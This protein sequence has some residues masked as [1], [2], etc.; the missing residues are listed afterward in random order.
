MASDLTIRPA[1][2]SDRPAMECVCAHTFD[3]GDYIPEVWDD[4]LADKQGTV[5]VGEVG[6]R[7]VAL[8]RITFQATGQVYIGG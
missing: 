7:M 6:E 3:W 8:S 5:I 2:A 1:R 4:W